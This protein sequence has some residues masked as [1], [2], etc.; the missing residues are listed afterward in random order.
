MKKPVHCAERNIIET[1]SAVW[2]PQQRISRR[3]L[4]THVKARN[5][6]NRFLVL[7]ACM[8]VPSLACCAPPD[9]PSVA[10]AEPVPQTAVLV[11]G[12]ML[13]AEQIGQLHAKYR[14]PI[15]PGDY[16]YDRNNG[17]WG[18]S[19]GPALGFL[20]PGEPI[21]G[22]LRADASA[23]DS[24][25]FINGRELH[26]IDVQNLDAIFAPFGTRTQRGRYWSDAHGNF[27]LEGNLAAIGNFKLMVAQA[28][29][30]T[31]GAGARKSNPWSYTTDY[32][33]FGSDGS[34]SYYESKRS[35]G[36]DKGYTGVY[37]DESG[38]VSYD[39]PPKSE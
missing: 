27:G 3:L 35:Y 9:A 20:M 38:S 2:E 21:G 12:T 13:S 10:A 28:Q 25:V 33:A 6:T 34:S 1:S 7:L 31:H 30:R 37:V 22:P 17:L 19:G 16:W 36:P 5:M 14:V 39:T 32:S 11:N 26:A 15:A 29:R 23:G 18:K 8:L 24:G 4:A